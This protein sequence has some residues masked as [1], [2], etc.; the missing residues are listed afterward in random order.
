MDALGLGYDALAARAARS[1]STARSPASA[2]GAGAALPGY[3]LLVQALGGLMSITGAPDGEPQK[4][5]VALV[6]VITGLFAAVGIL[7]ALRHRERTGEGQR[8]E[9]DLL[10]SLL[11]ALVNQGSAYTLAGAVGGPDGQRAPV[12][13]ALRAVPDRRRRPRPRRRQRPAVRRAVRGRRRWSRR[14]ALRHQQA[15]ASRTATRCATRSWRALAA[16]PAAEWVAALIAGARPGRRGQ[17]RR[18]RL[19]ASPSRSAWTRSSSSPREDGSTA[20][21]TRNPIGLSATPPTYRT[22]PPDLPCYLATDFSH[23]TNRFKKSFLEGSAV[24]GSLWA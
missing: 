3:D 11:A 17:R 24:L 23:G 7:A 15:R 9:V 16:R 22:A 5:G 21:L 13:R 14:R 1:W 19:R 10:S 8:V 4:A 6:D 20:R 18:G 2:A 12:D